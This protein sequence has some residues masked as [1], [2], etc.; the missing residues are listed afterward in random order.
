MRRL[1]RHGIRI[2]SDTRPKRPRGF[3]LV[4]LMI[5]LAL[6]ML[7]GALAASAFHAVQVAYRAAV[8]LVLL[9][10][11]GQRA[12]AV[13][14]HLIRHG[15]WRPPGATALPD[16]PPALSGRDDCGQPGIAA[17]P[18]CARRGVNGSDA[19]LVRF[20]GSGRAQDPTLPDQTMTDCSGYALP[21]ASAGGDAIGSG[22]TYAGANLLYV[23]NGADGEPQLLCR[24]SSR[25]DGRVQQGNWTS[26]AL[27]RGLETMQLRYGI[28]TD[29]DGKTDT[30]LRAEEIRARG[31][32]A[33][34]EVRVV[35][36][37]L[38]LR[39]ERP[40]PRAA[41]AAAL[42]LFPPPGPGAHGGDLVFDPPPG[43]TLMRRVFSTS[44]RLRNAS[45][46]VETLC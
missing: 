19:L 17:Q 37:A 18:T 20:S 44:V 22:G 11:R 29:G 39:G 28:D 23:A 7:A 14:S 42:V 5:G 45:P 40:L 1:C 30:F 32:A 31:E 46:C 26:G 38:V 12:I 16:T 34:H 21:A 4:E 41:A 25:R 36:V 24:Y 6:G 27:V 15:G 43:S 10:E 33:W 8:D 13:V 2:W 35:Q 9:E 3:S